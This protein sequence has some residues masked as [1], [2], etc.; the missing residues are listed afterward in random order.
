[1]RRI[2]IVVAAVV[3]LAGCATA[4]R[5]DALTSTLNAYAATLRWGSFQSALKFVDPKV[6]QMNP[7]TSLD[8]ARYQQV[9]VSDYDE[10]AGPSVVAENE[11]QQVVQLH[12]INIH[13]QSERT[14]IDRQTWRYDPEAKH[15]WLT[16]GL[17]NVT[18]D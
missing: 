4:Q 12:L 10:G 16:S 3:L 2:L 15:W 7:P 14:V 1:M 17:P 9:R 6:L 5:K 11:V 18:Q 8:M 13:T